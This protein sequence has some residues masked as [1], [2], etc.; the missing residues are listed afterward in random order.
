MMQ[1]HR[2]LLI[3]GPPRICDRRASRGG[4]RPPLTN[5]RHLR[6]GPSRLLR[7][8]GRGASAIGRRS[9]PRLSLTSSYCARF[10]A[11]AMTSGPLRLMCLSPRSSAEA[12]TFE[13][14]QG[15]YAK[16]RLRPG[17]A[18]FDHARGTLDVDRHILSPVL[19]GC[20]KVY[21]RRNRSAW[22]SLDRADVQH[23]AA[24]ATS[25]SLV[26]WAAMSLIH[27]SRCPESRQ[28]SLIAC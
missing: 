19:P 16:R 7:R 1:G 8:H 11:R 18:A 13:P 22:A 24:P 6:R 10:S 5:G 25:G 14:W 3:G 2:S 9:W 20:G 26:L 17:H 12:S 21:R 28:N 23:A 15:Q 27:R 4:R